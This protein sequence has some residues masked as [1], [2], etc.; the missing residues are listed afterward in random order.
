MHTEAACT[1]VV[2]L[3]GDQLA[4]NGAATDTLASADAL[5]LRAEVLLVCDGPAWHEHP[6]VQRHLL[7]QPRPG[8]LQTRTVHDHP[9]PLLNRALPWVRTP[10]LLLLWPGVRAAPTTANALLDTLAQE[11]DAA[12]A[13]A[14]CLTLLRTVALRAAGGVD[15]APV[16]QAALDRDLAARLGDG[17]MLAGS[18]GRWPWSRYPF[19]KRWPVPADVV[20]GYLETRHGSPALVA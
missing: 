7:H 14:G 1:T 15:P 12:L 13:H 2:L 4:V 18:A 16:L 8:L 19:R 6:A 20:A 10:Y 5:G 3:L 11:P 17:L 9:A